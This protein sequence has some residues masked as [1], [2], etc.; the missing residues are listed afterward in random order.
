ME[1]LTQIL[2]GWY[3]S[4]HEIQD[5]LVLNGTNEQEK[6]TPGYANGNLPIPAFPA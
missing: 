3:F 1:D 6:I 2:N 5:S 4:G